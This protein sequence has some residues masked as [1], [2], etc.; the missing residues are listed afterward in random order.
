MF[1]SWISADN[2]KSE[3]TRLSGRKAG[4]G[5]P[6]Q[7]KPPVESDGFAR[8]NMQVLAKGGVLYHQLQKFY[9]SLRNASTSLEGSS[10]CSQRTSFLFISGSFMHGTE[11]NR[12][13]ADFYGNTYCR[14]RKDAC[15]HSARNFFG[16]T[17]LGSNSWKSLFVTIPLSLQ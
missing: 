15:V 14:F 17:S 10:I 4:P 3:R 6:N 12:V 7:R 8:L 2:K 5:N 16:M 9:I 13:W 11:K 1:R